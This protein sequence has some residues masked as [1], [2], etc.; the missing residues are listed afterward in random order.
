MTAEQWTWIGRNAGDI[1]PTIDQGARVLSGD[2]YAVVGRAE[3]PRGGRRTYTVRVDPDGAEHFE[4]LGRRLPRRGVTVREAEASERVVRRVLGHGI[5]LEG[6]R[7]FS[8][9]EEERILTHPDVQAA[10]DEFARRGDD[11]LEARA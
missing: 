3:G 9:E 6:E 11:G 2:L 10:F 1:L 5:G 8:A 4:A 7:T